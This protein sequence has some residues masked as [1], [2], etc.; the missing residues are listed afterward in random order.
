MKVTID[1]QAYEV[2]VRGGEIVV[3]GKAFP[4]RA[5][6]YGSEVTIELAGKTLSA[7][8]QGDSVTLDGKTYNVTVEQPARQQPAAVA[9]RPAPAPRPAATYAPPRPAAPPPSRQAAPPASTAPRP[10]ATASS[11]GTPMKAPMPGKI[12]RV[13]VKEGDAVPFGGVLMVLE[14]MKMENE[15]K[16]TVAGTVSSLPVSAGSTVNAGETLA[17]IAG[18]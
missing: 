16:A 13:L 1:G 3:D 10:A 6:R 15:I 9:P 17:V 14:A 2:D 18:S 11:N 12:L 5:E 7:Q 4:V 8:L